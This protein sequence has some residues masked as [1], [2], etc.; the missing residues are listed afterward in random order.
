MRSLRQSIYQ[1]S[2]DDGYLTYTWMSVSRSVE[3]DYV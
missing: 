2:N 3:E 1:M